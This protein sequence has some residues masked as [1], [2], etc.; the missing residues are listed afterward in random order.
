MNRSPFYLAAAVCSC[1]LAP[2]SSAQAA[3][4]ENH[5]TRAHDVVVLGGTA[6]SPNF[7]AIPVAGPVTSGLLAFSAGSFALGGI[8]SPPDEVF[9][10]AEDPNVDEGETVTLEPGNEGGGLT[11]DAEVTFTNVDGGDGASVVV[12]E[13]EDPGPQPQAYGVLGVNLTVETSL[14]DGQFFMRAA[15]PMR[16]E[17][18]GGA[19]PSLLDL[20]YYDP[21][22]GEY[23]LAVAGNT[24]NSPNSI[25]AF[26]SP[27]GQ[28]Y[29]VFGPALPDPPIPSL[30]LGDYGVFWNTST[31]E[32]FVWANVDHTTVFRAGIEAMVE[33]GCGINPQ[34]SLAPLAG[35]PDL[36]ST[37]IVGVDDPLG[38]SPAG[39]VAGLLV[40]IAPDPTFPCGTQLPGYGMDGPTGELLVGVLPPNPVAVVGPVAW[41]GPGT[42]AAIAVPIPNVPS[43]SGL[44]LYLQGVVANVGSI[45]FTDG[46]RLTIGS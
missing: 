41:A 38:A 2:P 32:G 12:I 24:Q 30:D 9:K 31:K 39:S 11:E 1:L 23:V 22:L 3:V 45:K 14:A 17:D 44:V 7:R 16:A 8:L 10:V 46:L 40:S 18:L 13:N 15:V 20:A 27:V 29:E 43:L 6:S 4:S 5:A 28:R 42:P 37:V 25:P 33:Y 36:G 35:P 34:S 19:D 26:S 21:A